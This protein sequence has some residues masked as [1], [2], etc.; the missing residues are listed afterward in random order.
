M[1]CCIRFFKFVA[2]LTAILVPV[3]VQAVEPDSYE[4]DD[5]AAQAKVI[6]LNDAEPQK[7]SFHEAGDEDW[8]KFYGLGGEKYSVQA[9]NVGADCDVVIKLYDTDGVTFLEKGDDGGKGMADSLKSSPLSRDG[10]YYVKIYNISESTGENTQYDL[11][12]FRTDAPFS[13][14]FQG[15]AKDALSKSLLGNVMIKTD[16]N[17][18]ALSDQGSY[19]M[20]H[21]ISQSSTPYTLTAR[22]PGYQVFTKSVFTTDTGFKTTAGS[23]G[24]REE[25]EIVEWDGTIELIPLK[26]D[27]NGDLKVD[28]ADAVLG[29]QAA[30]GMESEKIRQDYTASRTDVGGDSKAGLEEAIHI[31]NYLIQEQAQ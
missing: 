21:P 5:S 12:I 23:S 30:A 11:R 29:L 17:F 26:G 6:T 10:I 24:K 18:T 9:D 20:Y 3:F 8:V 7:R 1:K 15:T 27:I 28:L 25:T 19:T 22:L 2:V 4:E 14:R 13:A 31:L 16:Q